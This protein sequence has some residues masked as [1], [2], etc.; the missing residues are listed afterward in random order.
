MSDSY[1][2]KLEVDGEAATSIAGGPQKADRHWL[3]VCQ[4]LAF[5]HFSLGLRA[6]T[7]EELGEPLTCSDLSSMDAFG[8]VG[9]E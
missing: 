7:R 5:L 6:C 8:V 1:P 3:G 4:W 2:I 9:C